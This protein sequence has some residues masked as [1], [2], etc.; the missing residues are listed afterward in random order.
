MPLFW[1]PPLALIVA[2]GR[3]DAW[4]TERDYAPLLAAV[5][6]HL[7]Q[8][9]RLPKSVA[10]LA[11]VDPEFVPHAEAFSSARI[12]TVGQEGFELRLFLGDRLVEG[13][14]LFSHAW[15]VYRSDGAAPQHDAISIRGG[16]FEVVEAD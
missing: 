8:R 13:G 7:D 2:T 9:G 12:R 10:A 15:L 4:V 6:R 1:I 11:E 16:W 14:F 3:F 5:E